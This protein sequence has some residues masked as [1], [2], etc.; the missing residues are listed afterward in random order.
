MTT[1]RP[2]IC[3]LLRASGKASRR[4]LSSS[5][6]LYAV[7]ETFSGRVT[8]G[9]ACRRWHCLADC[10]NEISGGE[11]RRSLRLATIQLLQYAGQIFLR[12]N[13]E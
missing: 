3:K 4:I 12:R 2:P 8:T 1:I 10:L 13:D 6:P 7:P 5:L 9:T 11:K